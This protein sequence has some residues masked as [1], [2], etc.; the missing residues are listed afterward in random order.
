MKWAGHVAHIVREEVN[1]R[2]W[3]QKPEGQ[4]PPGRARR[5]WVYVLI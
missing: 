3:A 4:R 5:R 2:F 1:K